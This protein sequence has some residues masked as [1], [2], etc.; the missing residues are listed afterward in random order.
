[1]VLDDAAL[2]NLRAAGAPPEIIAQAENKKSTSDVDVDDFEVWP[3]NWESLLFFI[4]ISNCWRIVDGLNGRE[5][6][7]LDFCQIE[8]VVRLF[9]FTSEKNDSALYDDLCIIE[10]EAKKVLNKKRG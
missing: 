5:F 3:E 10:E 6:V 2:K 8:S 7:G 1:M 9:G 4:R